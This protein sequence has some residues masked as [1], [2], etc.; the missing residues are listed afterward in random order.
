M[1]GFCIVR[2]CGLRIVRVV[3]VATYVCWVVVMCGFLVE[4]LGCRLLL[5]VQVVCL[6]VGFWCVC[7]ACFDI[8]CLIVIWFIRPLIVRGGC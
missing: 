3:I 2:E 5:M 7:C 1:F 4:P 6:S 8:G